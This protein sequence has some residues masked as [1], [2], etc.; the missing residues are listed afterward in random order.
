MGADGGRPFRRRFL[1][2]VT[3]LAL[4]VAAFVGITFSQG[5][6]LSS[7]QLDAT[8]VVT[9]PGQ[10]LRL[11]ANQNVAPVARSQIAITPAAPI[12]VSSAGEVIA[13]Q[14]TQPLSYATDYRVTVSH[15][16]SAADGVS[17]TLSYR[18]RTASPPLYFLRRSGDAGPDEIVRTGIRSPTLAVAYSAQH[19]SDFVVFAHA[20]AV[21][22][23]DSKGDSALAIVGS[24]G[25]VEPITLPGPGTVDLVRANLDSGILGFTFTSAGPTTAREYSNTLFTV[26]PNGTAVPQPVKGLGGTPLSV[27]DWAFV[28]GS[29][30]LVAQNID[31]SIVLLDT[32]KVGAVTPLGNFLDFGA[33]ASDGRSM[34]VT[35][36]DGPCNLT[37]ATGKSS[38]ITASPLGGVKPYGGLASVLPT[39]R[40]Q[41]DSIYD[42][43]IGGFVDHLA[44]DN[45]RTAREL[46]HPVDPRGSI[47]NFS[48]SP[49]NEYVAIEV[50][51]DVATSKPDGYAVN[52]RPRSVTTYFVD[53]ETGALVKSV[54]GFD[55][56]W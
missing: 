55:V 51:P 33:I 34:V 15:V 21:A 3:A 52:G 46:F 23:L 42:D 48:I 35:D 28:P 22:T 16:A 30:E 54:A 45:G 25:R 36:V 39:G 50:N 53:V 18:F 37:F 4:L 24:G 27:L 49:N 14:F 10:Q 9:R 17:S 19:I 29:S 11:F 44:Y 7:A 41:L 47:L 20:I 8:G 1:A 13:V 32:A 31:Q 6:K 26:D 40:V 38:P 56:S 43:A 2:V 5:P 12:S